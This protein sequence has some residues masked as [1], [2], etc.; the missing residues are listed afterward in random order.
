MAV[1]RA[2]HLRGRVLDQGQGV[3]LERSGD[4]RQFLLRPAAG[5]PLVHRQHRL[6]PHPPP[7]Q[8]H[9]ELQPARGLRVAPDAAG[10]AAADLLDQPQVRA[11]EAVGRGAQAHGRFPQARAGLR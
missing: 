6:P 2:A 7:G 5:D 9:P 8:P 1:L 10:G 11:T 4:R 3:G